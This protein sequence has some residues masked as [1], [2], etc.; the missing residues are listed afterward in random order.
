MREGRELPSRTH[1]T[2]FSASPQA[3][4]AD[5]QKK[6]GCGGTGAKGVPSLR[7]RAARDRSY[8][9]RFAGTSSATGSGPAML[10]TTSTTAA[11]CGIS[12]RR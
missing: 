4:T 12:S 9:R 10:R 11:F 6:E 8:R 1:P 5:P 3:A 2:F 7:P